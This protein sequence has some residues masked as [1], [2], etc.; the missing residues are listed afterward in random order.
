MAKNSQNYDRSRSFLLITYKLYGHLSRLKGQ[1]KGN[2]INVYLA[3]MKYAW[4]SKGYSCGVRYSTL[5]ADTGL[6]HRTT[7][8]TIQSLAKLNV[9]KIRRLRSANEYTINPIF[10]KS[11]RSKLDSLGV[12]N[13]QSDRSYL[14][15][16]NRSINNINTLSEIDKIIVN[17]TDMDS[18]IAS[19]S[20]LP[21]AELQDG[22]KNN[23]YYV[24]KAI[25]LKNENDKPK[26]EFNAGALLKD[27]KKKT[28][29]NY[30]YKVEYNKRN[31]I[32]PW[33]NKKSWENK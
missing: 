23:P 32:K 9:I 6:S 22:L 19:L 26:V 7:R 8:R 20:T 10:I 29:A 17:G 16:I 2:A 15:S 14:D 1:A 11:E 5:S 18:I 12:L 24:K 33:E 30:K 21:I 3:L 4:K 25:A 27:L 28:N 31:N 13:G